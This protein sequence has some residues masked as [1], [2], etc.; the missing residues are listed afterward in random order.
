MNLFNPKQL[1]STSLLAWYR[2]DSIGGSDGDAIG[3]WSDSSGNSRTMTQGTADK[4]P[5]YKVNIINSRPV[6][7]F[8]GGDTL[9]TG[10]QFIP[11]DHKMTFFFVAMQTS[12]ADHTVISNTNS[13][14]GQLLRFRNNGGT[15]QVR[16]L[17]GNVLYDVNTG[18]GANTFGYYTA[19]VDC[20]TIVTGTVNWRING[21]SI[22][23]SG[24]LTPI[25]T[26]DGNVYIGSNLDLGSYLTGD[27]AEILIYDGLMTAVNYKQVEAYLKFKYAL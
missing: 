15:Q 6:A 5:T 9:T 10:T 16:W 1:G 14:L 7:R 24:S 20:S 22:G 27:I 12:V 19:L 23:T 8:D 25:G 11:A 18:V 2:A 13:G 26:P 3:S 21:T 17:A 4:K